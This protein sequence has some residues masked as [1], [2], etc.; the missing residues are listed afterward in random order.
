M[1]IHSEK[2]RFPAY[3]RMMKESWCGPTR[4]L[5]YQPVPRG[6]QPLLLFTEQ[7]ML[8][9]HVYFGPEDPVLLGLLDVLGLKATFLRPW[10]F[11]C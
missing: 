10:Q 1:K 8:S 9:L 4:R 5:Q 7:C 3:S 2:A 11:F 6:C